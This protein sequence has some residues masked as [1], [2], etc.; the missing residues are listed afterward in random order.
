MGV[1]WGKI[2]GT[3]RKGIDIY[4]DFD[5][6]LKPIDDLIDKVEVALPTASGASKLEA[7]EAVS[8]VTVE[9]ASAK[10]PPELQTE[11]H[12]LRVEAINLGVAARNTAARSYQV[13]TRIAEILK[14]ADGVASATKD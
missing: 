3:V 13:G 9:A 1:P 11:L 8:R 7:V 5:P 6:R 12:A 10:L 14:Y 4:A 2:F